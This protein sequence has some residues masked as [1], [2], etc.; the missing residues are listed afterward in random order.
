MAH[1]DRGCSGTVGQRCPGETIHRGSIL[2]LPLYLLWR[3]RPSISWWPPQLLSVF[4]IWMDNSCDVCR[5]KA[6][7]GSH[8]ELFQKMGLP[9]LI[10]ER[11][12]FSLNLALS[13][14]LCLCVCV[15]VP[16][17][18]GGK[19]VQHGAI[20]C[21]WDVASTF[22]LRTLAN[23]PA[24]SVLREL[25]LLPLCFMAEMASYLAEA[26]LFITGNYWMEMLEMSEGWK[27][28]LLL[29]DCISVVAIGLGKGSL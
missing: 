23:V 9:P 8:T 3:E 19:Q 21:P 25:A 11:C 15:E 16:A 2:L 12:W 26:R 27:H 22:P 24:D 14:Q 13:F 5:T 10:C 17:G 7:L 18:E 6:M 28:R 4:T 1:T 29:P 20:F